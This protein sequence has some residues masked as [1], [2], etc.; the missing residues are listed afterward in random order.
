M[1]V[2]NVVT[3]LLMPRLAAYSSQRCVAKRWSQWNG[4]S[5]LIAERVNISKEGIAKCTEKS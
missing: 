2:K 4:D 3:E 1:V 5:S